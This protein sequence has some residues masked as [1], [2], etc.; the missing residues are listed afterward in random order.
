M[1]PR[2][3]HEPGAVRGRPAADAL[4]HRRGDARPS[5]A[6]PAH[7]RSPRPGE[8]PCPGAAWPGRL[9]RRPRGWSSRARRPRPHHGLL[10]RCGPGPGR[11][12]RSRYRSPRTGLPRRRAAGRDRRRHRP[13]C[14]RLPRRRHHLDRGR[15]GHPSR[16]GGLSSCAGARPARRAGDGH[17]DLIPARR[18]HRHRSDRTVRRRPA[19]DRA[20][21]VLRGR[22]A[23]GWHG[24]ILVARTART[25]S[26]RARC[27]GAPRTSSATPS[28]VR[29]SAAGRSASTRRAIGRSTA[30]ST[31]TSPRSRR[32][33]ATT[34]ATGSST[35]AARDQTSSSGWRDSASWPSASLA[36]S[37]MPATPG[38][39][40]ST[41]SASNA[42]SP[43]AR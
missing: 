23:D 20:D 15:T 13:G 12:H 1:D 7:E 30:S 11:A 35:A 42:S 6:R 43:I 19:G 33:R 29:T 9:R 16:A 40:P 25:A 31:R 34:T 28:V 3:R 10:P 41:R 2:R 21:E 8:Q 18:V 14:P 39:R 5:G 38:S 17:A 37:G 27:T 26:S 4:G 22:C 36:T 32:S 24:G